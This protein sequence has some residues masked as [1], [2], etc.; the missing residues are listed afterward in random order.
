MKIEKNADKNRNDDVENNNNSITNKMIKLGKLSIF[1]KNFQ[2]C[3]RRGLPDLT[4]LPS[5]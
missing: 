1:K 5:I 4:I 2:R 3:V